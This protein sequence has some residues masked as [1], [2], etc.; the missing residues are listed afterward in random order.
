MHQM[1]QMPEDIEDTFKGSEHNSDGNMVCFLYLTKLLT[2]FMSTN[3]YIFDIKFSQSFNE[4]IFLQSEVNG[5]KHLMISAAKV[6][7]N[8]PKMTSFHLKTSV[9]SRFVLFMIF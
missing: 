7:F 5:K 6:L 4:Q 8:S 1:P 3:K 9:E 2:S